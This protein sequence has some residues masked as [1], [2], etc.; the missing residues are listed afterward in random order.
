MHVMA[1]YTK[2][3]TIQHQG[4]SQKLRDSSQNHPRAHSF[5]F[6]DR[7]SSTD[8]DGNKYDSTE[9]ESTAASVLARKLSKY[10]RQ[11]QEL[12][13]DFKEQRAALLKLQHD[14]DHLKLE[15]AEAQ[16]NLDC[17]DMDKDKAIA[18]KDLKI[19][20]L[21]KERDDLTHQLR[22]LKVV[23]ARLEASL[24]RKD[25]KLVDLT[26]ERDNIEQDLRFALKERDDVV[27]MLKQ[28]GR[29]VEVPV[30]SKSQRAIAFLRCFAAAS[31]RRQTPGQVVPVD[32][33]V[34]DS[35]HSR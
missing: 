11:N 25:L 5:D 27:H 35:M 3:T 20:Q 12:S 16:S 31:T 2:T 15:H 18:S 26:E 23:E 7:V 21:V 6:A 32:A 28:I 9:K 29:S 4:D 8:D 34:V 24:H 10:K 19:L 13:E 33:I 17:K 22:E 30:R 1:G 14:Y